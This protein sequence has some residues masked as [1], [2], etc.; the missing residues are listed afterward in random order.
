[1]R[2][3]ANV[4]SSYE[5]GDFFIRLFSG[6]YHIVFEAELRALALQFLKRV[7]VTDDE[8]LNGQV[9]AVAFRHFFK[10]FGQS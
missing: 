10:Q 1:V 8:Q 6:K 4:G 5:F 3:Q 2:Q 7:A 9:R